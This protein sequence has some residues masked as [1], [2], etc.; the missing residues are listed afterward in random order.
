MKIEQPL[1]WIIHG[2]SIALIIIAIILQGISI[3]KVDDKDNYV[4]GQFLF[5]F[6]IF[7]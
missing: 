2:L 1:L 7:I 6:S 4:Y 3:N 5:L